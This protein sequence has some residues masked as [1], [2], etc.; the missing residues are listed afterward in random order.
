MRTRTAIFTLGALVAYLGGCYGGDEAQPAL[1]GSFFGSGGVGGTTAGAGG[2]TTAGT[3]GTTAA[4]AGGIAGSGGT[5]AS[6][7]GGTGGAAVDD[8]GA[9]GVVGTGGDDSAVGGAGGTGGVVTPVDTCEGKTPQR[10]LPYAVGTDFVYPNN[11]SPMTA[12][13]D[14]RW[15]VLTNPDCMGSFPDGGPPEFF[16]PDGGTAD[17]GTD[18]GGIDTGVSEAST[19]DAEASTDD[20]EASTDDAEASTDDAEASTDDASTDASTVSDAAAGDG[21]KGD[22]ATAIPACWGFYYNP[23][24]CMNHAADAGLATWQ[25]WGGSIFETTPNDTDA[26][27]PANLPGI[28]IELGATAI[29][30]EARASRPAASVKFGSTRAGIQVTEQWVTVDTA[31]T[32]YSIPVVAD[33]RWASS[34]QYGVFNGFSVVVEPQDH[35]GGTFIFVR[36]MTWVKASGD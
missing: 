30:F 33:Y 28:C 32:K 27:D 9:D 17:A 25:C 26:G 2:G 5:D 10:S 34:S 24:N 31:W 36:N 8:S 18:G 22:A 20:A 1:P 7:G 23:D 35:L 6:A 4:G 13:P 11:V 16:P 14:V 29:E 21:A 12:M 19:D 3:G 15:V